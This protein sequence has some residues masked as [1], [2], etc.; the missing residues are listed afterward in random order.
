MILLIDIGNTHTHFGLANTSRV[1]QQTDIATKDW[2]GT[3]VK[4][5]KGFVGR[6]ALDGAAVCS[7]V[8][9]ATPLAL[10]AV[11]RSWKI[12]ALELT[13]RTIR[14]I[15][16]RY[17]KPGTIGSD[18]LA[19]AVAINHHYG[20]PS[21][22]VDFGTAVTFDV[23]EAGGPHQRAAGEDRVLRAL[24]MDRGLFAAEAA[25]TCAPL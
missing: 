18:R 4:A 21:V 22:A 15:G 24:K 25:G 1:V 9:S 7:V 8:P 10:L 14:G 12:S 6:A 16:I 23:V 11:K 2:G 13:P 19:N 20:A 17:P 3:A 5:M